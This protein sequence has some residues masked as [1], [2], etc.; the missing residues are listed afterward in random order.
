MSL[1]ES[2]G[3]QAVL[4]SGERFGSDTSAFGSQHLSGITEHYEFIIL[5]L[6]L[7]AAN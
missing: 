5:L 6:L 2:R 3:R 1:G 4:V 7:L